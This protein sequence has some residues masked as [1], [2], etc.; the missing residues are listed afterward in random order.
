MRGVGGDAV[1]GGDQL[2]GEGFADIDGCIKGDGVRSEVSVEGDDL[3][4]LEN[5]GDGHGMVR[6]WRSELDAMRVIGCGESVRAKGRW[7]PTN[8]SRRRPGARS[9]RDRGAGFSGCAVVSIRGTHAG[10]RRWCAGA[11]R[12]W[13]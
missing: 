7:M 10:A 6:Q 5:F 2:R 9:E 3:E 8:L 4:L 11:S 12:S 1:D 13:R